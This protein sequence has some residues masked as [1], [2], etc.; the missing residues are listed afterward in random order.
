[1]I[2][3]I[4]FA[5]CYVY[6]PLGS[7]AT[8][9]RSRRLCELLKSQDSRFICKYALRV[10]QQVTEHSALSEFIE[11]RDVLVPM[12]G[13]SPRAC[14]AGTVTWHLSAAL[15]GEGLGHSV[16]P[17]L[18]RI[19]AVQKSAT[20]LPGTRPSV[21]CHYDSFAIDPTDALPS[22]VVLVDDIV[23]KGRTLL[24]AAARLHEAFP[25]VRIRGFALVRTMGLVPGVNKLLDPCVGQIRWRGG[26]A[27][28]SP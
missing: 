26:D 4:T 9:E 16:W 7:G 21:G 8:S 17:G 20:A 10:R 2:E 28:R 22:Q 5:S 6:S 11:P 13:S 15:R 23:T 19:R 1:M 27:E 18:R 24:A 25:G 12:P 3:S 14:L